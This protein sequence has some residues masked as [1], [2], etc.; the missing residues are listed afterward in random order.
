MKTVEEPN[1]ERKL[2]LHRKFGF[3]RSEAFNTYSAVAG[4]ISIIVIVIVTV[5][6]SW[7]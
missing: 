1:Q 2:L 6:G 5:I 4:L 3:P 7:W